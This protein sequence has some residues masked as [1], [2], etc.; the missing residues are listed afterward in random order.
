[1]KSRKIATVL[2]AIFAILTF[3]L[4]Q[5]ASAK[6]GDKSL[7]VSGGFNS[8]N[9]SGIA[10]LK[11]TYDFASHVRI[12][13]SAEYTFRHNNYDAFTFNLDM[14]F[15]WQLTGST[16]SV[17]PIA[18]FNFTRWTYSEFSPELDN[19]ISRRFDRIGLNLGGGIGWHVTGAMK[20]TLEGQYSFLRQYGHALIRAGIAY[21]F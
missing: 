7:G 12:A 18:G 8:Y 10:G 21:S 4:P 11:F 6:R 15:P 5:E 3:S 17:Y 2:M 13:P 19:D 20:L 14:Q 9:N 1:M 16:V